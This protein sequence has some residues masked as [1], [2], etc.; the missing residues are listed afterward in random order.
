MRQHLGPQAFIVGLFEAA[1]PGLARGE[2]VT[3]SKL[4]AAGVAQ[5]DALDDQPA[6]LAT[7]RN[8]LGG[9]Y[10]VMGRFSASRT[11]IWVEISRSS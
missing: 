8:T 7:L 5:I 10:L 2:D 6:V 4:L 3:A 11:R 9:V 1:D